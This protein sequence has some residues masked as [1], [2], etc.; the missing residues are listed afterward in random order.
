MKKATNQKTKTKTVVIVS[1]FLLFLVL[2]LRLIFPKHTGDSTI[3]VYP[4]SQEIDMT[5]N[6]QDIRLY[7]SQ[8]LKFSIDVSPKYRV[9][10]M[11]N[12]VYLRDNEKEIMVSKN[13]TNFLTIDEYVR[14]LEKRNKV[15]INSSYD[16]KID[17]NPVLVGYIAHLLSNL[18]TEK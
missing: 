5:N 17:G 12:S 2:L 15:K 6:K 18:P 16:A 1:F 13:N 11:G 7:T 9:S 10:E 4:T 8:L 14:E 3:N